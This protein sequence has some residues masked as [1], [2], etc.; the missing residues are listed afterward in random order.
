M[1]ITYRK[2]KMKGYF[3][4]VLIIGMM[5]NLNPISVFEDTKNKRLEKKPRFK[6]IC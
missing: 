4:F 5:K 1:H 6:V 3:I 2:A